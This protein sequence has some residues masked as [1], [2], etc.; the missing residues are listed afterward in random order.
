MSSSANTFEATRIRC[1][2]CNCTELHGLKKLRTH[3]GTDLVNIA[4]NMDDKLNKFS[5]II[6]DLTERIKEIES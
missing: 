4:E 1:E 6:S 2:L 5:E 3:R